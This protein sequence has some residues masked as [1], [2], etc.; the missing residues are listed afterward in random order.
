MLTSFLCSRTTEWQIGRL[1]QRLL[2]LQNAKSLK[3]GEC[4][5]NWRRRQQLEAQLG[6]LLAERRA[7]LH[8]LYDM[9]YVQHH[10]CC[11]IKDIYLNKHLR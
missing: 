5:D 2:S 4:R 9:K 1:E 7:H 11:N 3:C 6:Q 10:C 8:E